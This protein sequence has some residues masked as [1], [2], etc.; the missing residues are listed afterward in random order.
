M[1][2]CV[3]KG[4]ASGPNSSSNSA[5]GLLGGSTF[6]V[7]VEDVVAI[8]GGG[9]SLVAV[10][11]RPPQPPSRIRI[12]RTAT[13]ARERIR[14]FSFDRRYSRRTPPSFAPLRAKREWNGYGPQGPHR[15]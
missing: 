6:V 8:G 2:V 11:L 7:S 3:S 14:I 9:G 12:P 15:S 10:V 5:E 1:P 4:L 13:R